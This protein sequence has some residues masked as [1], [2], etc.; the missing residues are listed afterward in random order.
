M[1]RLP[2]ERSNRSRRLAGTNTDHPP[3]RKVEDGCH[4]APPS[5]GSSPEPERDVAPLRKLNG[6]RASFELFAT[7]VKTKYGGRFEQAGEGGR[8]RGSRAAQ[9]GPPEK[10]ADG[11]LVVRQRGT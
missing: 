4:G 2:P 3:G 7:R 1:G 9:C 10:G 8:A 6:S 11:R 5:S